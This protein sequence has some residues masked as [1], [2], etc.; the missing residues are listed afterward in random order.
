MLKKKEGAESWCL[1][2]QEKTWWLNSLAF[3]NEFK[4]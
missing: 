1:R 4:V 3:E 2:I